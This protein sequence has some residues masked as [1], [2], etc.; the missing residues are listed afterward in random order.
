MKR[1]TNR[2]FTLMELMVTMAIIGIVSAIAIPNM[3]GWRAK[4]SL[5]G[6]INNLQADMQ[7][8]RMRAV[9]EGEVVAVLFER[10]TRSYRIFVDKNNNWLVDADEPELRQVTLPAGI[11]ISK[12]TFASDRTRFK[13]NGMPSVIGT[14][15]LK[16]DTG[17][18]SLVVNR[19]GRL[20]TE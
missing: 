8:A 6:A 9:R 3:V 1:S 17:E 5:Q 14:V 2:G 10:S 19:V 13:A 12:C 15:A 20:R 16:N 11:T 7:L 4:R 18:H